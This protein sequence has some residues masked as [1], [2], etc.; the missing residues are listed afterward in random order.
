MSTDLYC[1]P[2]WL[3]GQAIDLA[4][5]IGSSRFVRAQLTDQILQSHIAS[6]ANSSTRPDFGGDDGAD[7]S[8]LW[9]YAVSPGMAFLRQG[10]GNS[11]IQIA[12]G[13][14]LQKIANSDG[15]DSTLVPF[16]FAGTEE[17]TLTN[18]DATNP[19]VDLLQMKL[20]YIT[21]TPSS[22]DFQDAV[23][24]ANTS[25][26]GTNTRRRIQCTLSVKA[27]TPAASP[28]IPDP[29]A[30]FVP[31]G[32]AVVGHGWTTAGAAPIFGIDTAE[33]NN[34]VV[35]DQRMPLGVRSQLVT[36]LLYLLETAFALSQVNT[37]AT[38]SNATNLMFSRCPT[39]TG[40]LLGVDV[41]T[42]QALSSVARLVRYTPSNSPGNPP[43]ANVAVRN[44][45]GSFT[46]LS[47]TV[48]RSRRI[49]FEAAH[50]PHVGPTVLQSATNK[51]GVPLW[52][53]GLRTP[54]IPTSDIYSSIMLRL[55]NIGNGT[56]IYDTVWYTA[57]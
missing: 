1:T 16:T 22:V 55:Q 46:T 20:E 48:A 6:V 51:I 3:D 7:S 4:S 39:I 40:R 31:V 57:G 52:A 14:L 28:V 49:D 36:P 32:S 33:I 53:N 27:G 44:G 34:V 45:F 10:S 2:N 23:T 21:D 15:V 37:V 19:R 12:P 30:G 54:T 41:V 5:L 25:D 17:F 56:G 50:V 43:S 11:K 8:T 13:T 24:R 38:S 18:G 35:H 29:D 26:G 47:G 9:A 42:I